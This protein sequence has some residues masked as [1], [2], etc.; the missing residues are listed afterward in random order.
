MNNDLSD[1]LRQ[2]AYEQ[3]ECLV[4]A[5]GKILVLIHSDI[6][7][8]TPRGQVKKGQT[9]EWNRYLRL[10]SVADEARVVMDNYWSGWCPGTWEK[11]YAE[12]KTLRP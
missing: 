9:I 1:E 11:F 4:D 8:K 3:Q 5:I 2:D 6:F 10:L 7:T 12:N